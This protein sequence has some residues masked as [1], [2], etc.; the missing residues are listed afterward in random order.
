MMQ[1]ELERLLLDSFR[2]HLKF[3]G[4]AKGAVFS[5]KPGAIELFTDIPLG[6]F[7]S[8]TFSDLDLDGLVKKIKKIKEYARVSNKEIQWIVGPCTRPINTEE[9]LKDMGFEYSAKMVGMVLDTEEMIK[10]HQSHVNHDLKIMAVK[11]DKSL[12]N[13]VRACMADNPEHGY[14][15]EKIFL[16]E[17]SLGVSKDS[18]WI[19]FYAKINNEIAA[20]SA[21]FFAENAALIDNI[22]TLKEYRRK[23]IAKSLVSRMIEIAKSKGYHRCVLFS[24]EMGE[25]LYRSL[26]FKGSYIMEIYRFKENIEDS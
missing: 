2:K 22:S 21:L 3:Y 15:F 11:N 8:I 25:K 4:K 14:F 13:W 20:T 10:S 19:R 23:G 17:K 12:K 6:P 1:K 5:A 18:D 16:F 7:N 24:S 26:G 9:I